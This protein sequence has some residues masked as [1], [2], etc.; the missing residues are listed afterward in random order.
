MPLIALTCP[1]CGAPVTPS[2]ARLLSCEYCKHS[3][4]HEGGDEVS[5]D[6]WIRAVDADDD[7]P[8]DKRPHCRVLGQKFFLQG[9]LGRGSRCDV[10]LAERARRPT[11]RVVLKVLREGLPDEGL[12]SEWRLLSLLT[13]SSLRGAPRMTTLLPQPVL[14]GL[15]TRATASPRPALVYRWKSGYQHS[16]RQVREAHPDGIDARTAVWI[17]RRVVEQLDWLHRN[18][19]G[20]GAVLPEHVLVHPRDHS[21]AIVGWSRARAFESG[22]PT[23]R[24]DLAG[25]ARALLFAMAGDSSR[26]P[27][28][29]GSLLTQAL[30]HDADDARALCADIVRASAAAYGP[31][32]YH[33]F[34]MP[35]W[36]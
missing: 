9:L 16:L 34:T 25:S 24:E 8:L 3:L 10:W 23:V 18:G 27:K 7:E 20:H 29:I 17:W 30:A 26:A 33:P 32:T 36:P 22:S 15:F 13:A 4:V 21:V 35:G 19:V 1:A 6:L 11:E 2:T 5:W 14:R 31:P 12:A 28:P